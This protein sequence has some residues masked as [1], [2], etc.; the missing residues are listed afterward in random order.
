MKELKPFTQIR[1][2]G[3]PCVVGTLIPL[4]EFGQRNAHYTWRN[5]GFRAFSSSGTARALSRF[6]FAGRKRRSELQAQLSQLPKPPPALSLKE[7]QASCLPPAELVRLLPSTF[8]Q[9]H[10]RAFSLVLS[11]PPGRAAVTG[12]VC[13]TLGNRERTAKT[14]ASSCPQKRT[15]ELSTPAQHRQGQPQEGGSKTHTTSGVCT[16]PHGSGNVTLS[17]VH[18][19]YAFLSPTPR[20]LPLR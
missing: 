20:G 15:R 11:Y 4:H 7:T 10:S 19:S 5:S 18:A 17:C 16:R 13:L 14:T 8:R 2:R 1:N 3:S 9:S 12:S 6:W